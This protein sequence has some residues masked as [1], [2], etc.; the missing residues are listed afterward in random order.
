MDSRSIF[1]PRIKCVITHSGTVERKVSAFVD[2]A[3]KPVGES[4]EVT[5]R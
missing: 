5:E 1:L 2:C 4:R 3:S